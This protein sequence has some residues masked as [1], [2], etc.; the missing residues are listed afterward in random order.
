MAEKK[1]NIDFDFRKVTHDKIEKEMTKIDFAPYKKLAFLSITLSVFLSAGLTVSNLAVSKY[2][3]NLQI[4]KMHEESKLLLES[5]QQQLNIQN[6]KNTF[7]KQAVDSEK[8]IDFLAAK[9]KSI[10]KN[11]FDKFI[12][13]LEA[14]QNLYDERV[15][16]IR[17]SLF[18]AQEEDRIHSIDPNSTSKDLETFVIK[19]KKDIEETITKSTTIYNSVKDSHYKEDHLPM[20]DLQKFM[21]LYG[22]F[23]NGLV[24]EN[25]AIESKIKDILYVKNEKNVEYNQKHD[26]F[27]SDE[28]L[29][30][31]NIQSI[32]KMKP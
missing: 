21:T 14:H 6:Q 19:Y 32:K 5:Q 9:I 22:Q 25:V 13:Y 28:K 29:N 3:F 10:D 17:Q 27:N 23:N 7:D 31:N 2:N 8:N 24:L 15:K 11:N 30:N 26:L 12:T 20:V 4:E 18:A 1:T 16:L